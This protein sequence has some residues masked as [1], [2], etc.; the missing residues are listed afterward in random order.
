[1]VPGILVAAGGAFLTFGGVL[2]FIVA[3]SPAA[4]YNTWSGLFV[5]GMLAGFLCFAAG[6]LILTDSR[7]RRLWGWVA[8]SCS[9]VGM[10]LG[11][12]GLIVGFF[13]ALVGGLMAIALGNQTSLAISQGTPETS[14][15]RKPA[16]NSK[17]TIRKNAQL[18]AALAVGCAVTL[19]GLPYLTA[20]VLTAGFLFAHPEA[21]DLQMIYTDGNWTR[22]MS[23]SVDAT[24][25]PGDCG[26]GF[27]YL[28]NGYTSQNY[29]YQVGLA[30]DWFGGT[31]S[32]QLVYEVFGPS[33]LSVY[34]NA[35]GGAGLAFFSKT[36][37]SGDSILLN[38]SLSGGS[39]V[40]S[41]YDQQTGGTASGGSY[42][43]EGA[44]SFQA[45]EA[46]NP[47]GGT[48][49]GLMTECY[50]DVPFGFDL[51]NATYHD[52]GPP[53]PKGVIFIDE[54]DFS[55]GRY[56]LFGISA[57][58]TQS[59]SALNLTSP[60]LQVFTAYSIVTWANSTD[61]SAATYE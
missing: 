16:R 54:W 22:G 5:G 6:L 47:S 45:G 34:P 38:L 58:P 17:Q 26:Y 4:L 12:G 49:T 31:D 1:M 57:F 24:P 14:E 21:Y 30:Y 48:F 19:A 23:Y 46:P 37:S 42:S 35:G 59:S 40:M 51:A 20:D 43:S 27:A 50:R 52:V 32:F 33:G 9:L 28:V 39:V 55:W 11:F 18:L 60:G 3:R 25:Q 13:A 7:R 44:A 61:F 2:F 29:W 8:F 15:T 36:V 41:G 10:F 53:Q 56:P